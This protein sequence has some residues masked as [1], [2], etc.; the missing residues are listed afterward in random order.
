MHESITIA[1]LQAREVAMG[2]F[3]PYLKQ[4]NVTEQQWR[5]IR[6]LAADS[7]AIDFYSLACRTC[8]LRPS[9]TGIL[10]RMERDGMIMRMKPLSDQRKLYI[11]LTPDG[12][13]L[14]DA[15]CKKVE[16]GY[17]AIETE[18]STE[19]MQQLRQLLADMISLGARQQQEPAAD[20]EQDQQQ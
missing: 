5:I 12:Q 7:N 2:Y 10:T 11:S 3:R 20:C 16:D 6:V 9:L 18:F 17:Q 19:K 4:H 15:V 14:Y 1:L 8:I 13:S